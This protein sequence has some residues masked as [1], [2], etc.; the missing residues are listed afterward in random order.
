[1]A[2]VFPGRKVD[3]VNGQTGVVLV[4]EDYQYV[5]EQSMPESVWVI[6]LGKYASVTTVD[7][8]GRRVQGDEDYSVEG[9]VTITFNGAFSGKAFLN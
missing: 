4:T 1:M 6:P 2:N 3:S 8:T 7:S 9:Q 5:F